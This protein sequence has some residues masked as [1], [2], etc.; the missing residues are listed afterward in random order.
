MQ[1]SVPVLIGLIVAATLMAMAAK[2]MRLPYSVALVAGGM[3]I[4]VSGLLPVVPRLAPE[5]VFL[6]CLPALLFEGGI[7]ADVQG[8]RA[9]AIPIAVL[10]VVGTGIAIGVTAVALHAFLDLP[11]IAALLLA[12][13]MGGTDTVSIL[14]TFRRLVVPSRLSGIMSGETLF[15]DGATL[16]AYAAIAG[17]LTEGVAPAPGPMAGGLL[18]STVGGAAIGLALAAVGSMLVRRTEDPLAEL[19]A[20]TAIA[21]GAYTAANEVGVSG[22]I[23][24]VSAGLVVGATARAHLPPQSRIALSSFWEYVAF[25]VNTFLFLLIGLSTD[26]VSIGSH[27]GE[28]LAGFACVLGGRAAAIYV[29]FLFVRWLRPA[30]WVPMRWQHVFVYGNIKGALAV[31]LALGLPPETPERQVLVDV[32]FGVSFV[33]LVFQ[34]STLPVVVRWLGLSLHDPVALGLGEQQARLVAARAARQELDQLFASGL[35]PR[36]GY[37]QLRS[38]YQVEIARAER[39]LRSLHERH[40]AHGAMLLLATRRRLVDAERTAV[41]AAQRAGL[42]PTDAA[43]RVLA[44]LDD[45]VLR[46]ERVLAGEAPTEGR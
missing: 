7:S 33:S 37:D 19:M 11:W 2:R 43:D 31:A 6:V 39:T 32:A 29:P 12:A 26:P 23:A 30:H 28:I 38:D 44:E 3:A 8:I 35:V 13:L 9:N 27:I 34:G 46:I 40:L 24:A 25:G 22:A 10:A 1:S 17:V 36:S 18:W 16:V 14:F 20:T 41:G 5:T 4:A 42:V 21:Y 15:N 45:E